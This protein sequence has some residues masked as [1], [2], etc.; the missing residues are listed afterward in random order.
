MGFAYNQRGEGT[1]VIL[2]RGKRAATLRGARVAAFLAESAAGEPQTVMAR[3]SGAYKFGNER[4][5][6][7]RPRNR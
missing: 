2:H 1:V 5:A 7:S 3:W 4:T 6:R